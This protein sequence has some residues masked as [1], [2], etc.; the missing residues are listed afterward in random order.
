[1]G[2]I[3][4]VYCYHQYHQYPPRA[5]VMDHLYSF[6]RHSGQRCF[7]L[8]LAL[9]GVPSYLLKIPFDLIVFHT[10]FL[11]SRWIL[12]RFKRAA[13]KVRPLKNNP[14]V[15][16][17]LPQDEFFHMDV[18][19]DF[20]NEF[21]IQHVFSVSPP[22][23]WPK[24][25]K[26]V[27]FK[28]VKFHQV[29]TGYLDNSTVDRID[30][31]AKAVPDR[32]ID[33]GYRAWRAEP[34]L[35]RHG[36]LKA[37][38][39]D[40]FLKTALMNGLTSD[41]STRE[42]DTLLGNDWYKFLL[43]C[44]YTIGTEGGASLL[45]WDGTIRRKTQAYILQRPRASFNEIEAAC[46]AGLDGSLGLFAISPRHL[47]A[48]ATRTCQVL[49]EGAYNGILAPGKHYI[50]FK[51]DFSN[52]KQV[53]T[54]IRDDTRR[55]EIV[56]NAYHDVVASGRYRYQSFVNFIL[57][58]SLQGIK[59]R[60]ISP[61]HTPRERLAWRRTQRADALSWQKIRFIAKLVAALPAPLV[62][63]LYRWRLAKESRISPGKRRT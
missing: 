16:V 63:G 23:E 9:Q 37:Q 34:W 36:F 1:M 13:E 5:A 43:Q 19:C 35:G 45:D 30:R 24:V 46:F 57:E 47:E 22:S 61:T 42:E 40:C 38:V 21:G 52:L 8:N 50:E 18:V 27:D 44:K 33:V 56:E 15:K 25:Y 48:C 20:I 39:A 28:K 12:P 29:L 53:M 62:A 14:A 11:A 60:S 6:E 26:T 49:V 31:L 51:R 55:T 7:Y 58:Q 4:I 3:L 2:N 54:L 41:I 32:I 10:K 59:P 17:A